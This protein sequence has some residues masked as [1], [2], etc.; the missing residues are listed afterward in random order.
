MRITLEFATTA[1]YQGELLRSRST[2]DKVNDAYLIGT[3]R[4]GLYVTATELRWVRR[5]QQRQ[6]SRICLQS[7]WLC[8]VLEYQLPLLESCYVLAIN[9]AVVEDAC[10]QSR[11]RRTRRCTEGRR[12]RAGWTASIPKFR[13]INIRRRRGRRRER[14]RSAP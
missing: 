9:G 4:N 11:F 13:K 3:K 2:R 1:F 5:N 12:R 10:V 6:G 14:R 8:V 7:A